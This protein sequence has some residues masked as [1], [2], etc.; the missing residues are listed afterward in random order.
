MSLFDKKENK[1]MLM[2]YNCDIKHIF[3]TMERVREFLFR[4]LKVIFFT[5]YIEDTNGNDVH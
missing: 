4:I 1:N 3:S 2:W 5:Y